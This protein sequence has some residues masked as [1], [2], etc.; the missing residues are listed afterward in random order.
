[1]AHSHLFPKVI[2]WDLVMRGAI[3][4]PFQDLVW[5]LVVLRP[6]GEGRGR[7]E[8]VCL[9]PWLREIRVSS[10]CWK[11]GFHEGL[12]HWLSFF[13]ISGAAIG[14]LVQGKRYFQALNATGGAFSNLRVG[15]VWI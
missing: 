1:M 13:A 3:L 15:R 4:P 8:G 7:D 11:L 9:L 6:Q 12:H 2:N 10:A 5:D 14:I